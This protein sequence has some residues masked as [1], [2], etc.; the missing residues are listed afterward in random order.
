MK[1][2]RARC[3][4]LERDT[5]AALDPAEPPGALYVYAAAEEAVRVILSYRRRDA[6][7]VCFPTKRERERVP[8]A[9]TTQR[10]ANHAKTLHASARAFVSLN[11]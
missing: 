8:C 7:D 10:G 2:P 1:K 11:Q 3:N 9:L 5:A 4:D 6:H